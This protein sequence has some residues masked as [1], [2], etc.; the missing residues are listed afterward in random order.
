MAKQKK[1]KKQ[2]KKLTKAQ[3]L[4]KAEI[5][6]KYEWIFINGKQVRVKKQPTI[7]GLTK[8]EFIENNADSIWLHQNGMWE[9]M[10]VEED[11]D[12]L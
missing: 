5:K 7:D 4:A 2:K 12:Y 8:D 10:E 1:Q 6:K 3:K 11:T 9:H